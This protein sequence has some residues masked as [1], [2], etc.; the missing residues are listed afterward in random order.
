MPKHTRYRGDDSK[1][2]WRVPFRLHS[3]SN[4]DRHLHR[5]KTF[6]KIQG[7]HGIAIT[8]SERA[9]YV[10]RTDIATAAVTDINPSHSTCKIAERDRSQE[11]ARDHYNCEREH[12]DIIPS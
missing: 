4:Q 2:L 5:A 11:I 12:E 6:Q 8:L 1:H 7:E 3:G 9:Y 10:G